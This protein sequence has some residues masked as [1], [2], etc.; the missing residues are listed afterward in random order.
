M[1][2]PA[3]VALA[4]FAMSLPL[5]AQQVPEFAGPPAFLS[6]PILLHVN[7]QGLEKGHLVSGG[8]AAIPAPLAPDRGSADFSAATLSSTAAILAGADRDVSNSS[9]SY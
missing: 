9:D 7:D 4:L 1:K 2:R 6:F 8:D 5:A 3:A